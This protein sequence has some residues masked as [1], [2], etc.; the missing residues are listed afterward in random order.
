MT[1]NNNPSVQD[2][3]QTTPGWWFPYLASGLA[4][5]PGINPQLLGAQAQKVA[6]LGVYALWK[7]LLYT[8]F[9]AYHSLS[10]TSQRTL[11]V[12]GSQNADYLKGLNPYWR[13]ALQHDYGEHYVALGTYGM[14]FNRY[15]GNDRSQ[16]ADRLTDFAVDATYQATLA[17]GDHILSVYATALREAL[18]LKATYNNPN[19]GGSDNPHDHLSSFRANASYSYH[20]RYGLTLSRFAT[21]GSTDATYFGTDSGKPNA[22]GW[23]TQFDVTPFGTDETSISTYLNARFFIQYTIYDRYNGSKTNYDGTG[24]NASD[25]NTIFTGVWM[26]F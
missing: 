11:G 8:E 26:A 16:S 12:T 15:P 4:P 24:R 25:N 10:P 3:W 13:V 7:D 2:V 23:T 19:T 17:G 6:G 5:A 18:N 21:F 22:S 20:N 1:V 9:S 14:V